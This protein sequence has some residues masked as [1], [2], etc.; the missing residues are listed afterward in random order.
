MRQD[1]ADYDA[2]LNI[3]KG[4]AITGTALDVYPVEPLPADSPPRTLHN[5]CCHPTWQERVQTSSATTPAR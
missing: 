1:R 5:V 2:L 3:L 4:G